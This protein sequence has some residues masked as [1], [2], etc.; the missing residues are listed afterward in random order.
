[1]I[2]PRYAFVK[3]KLTSDLVQVYVGGCVID[4]LDDEP[5]YGDFC[6][7]EIGEC[8]SPD[9]EGKVEVQPRIEI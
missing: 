4:I 8:K 7:C 6:G 1:M 3:C 5:S 9:Q 2:G